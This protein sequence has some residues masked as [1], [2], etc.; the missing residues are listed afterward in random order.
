VLL[1]QHLGDKEDQR[2]EAFPLWVGYTFA[3]VRPPLD[4]LGISLRNMGKQVAPA[5]QI[6]PDLSCEDA[7]QG[8]VIR[9]LWF[10]RTQRA[11]W[12]RVHATPS[13]TICS[14]NAAMHRSPNVNF[15]F[16]WRPGLPDC[17]TTREQLQ[18]SK[19]N[20]VRRGG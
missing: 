19:E 12:V 4:Q 14:P 1:P 8:N 15:A 2:V 5:Q 3:I 9:H 17:L 18:P 7:S 13:H 16:G 20:L 11:D 10:L 6:V